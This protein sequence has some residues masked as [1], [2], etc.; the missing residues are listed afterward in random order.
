M[1][2][3][4]PDFILD[5]RDSLQAIERRLPGFLQNPKDTELLNEVFRGV[6]TIKGGSAFIPHHELEQ[7]ADKAEEILMGFR[8]GKT[9]ANSDNLSQLEN[10]IQNIK[11]LIQD[12]E[13]Q[14]EESA[15]TSW[16][17]QSTQSLSNTAQTQGKKVDI[18]IEG[19]EQNEQILALLRPSL[20]QILQ[21]SIDHGIE[22][23]DERAAAGKNENASILIKVIKD[24]ENLSITISDDGRGIDS[25]ALRAKAVAQGVISSE[26]ASSMEETDIHQLIF[27]PGLST[28]EHVTSTAG[29]G[30]GMDI[31]KS[32]IEK[33]GGRIAVESTPK[34]GCAFT[35]QVPDD[36]H[37]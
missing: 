26:Q 25:E 27:T 16:L 1:N 8:D 15:N 28:T 30:V 20:I 21:N 9:E 33:S 35:I 6:H 17:K 32:N 7:E 29:R 23:S 18:Q 34:Q 5:A 37:S 10:Q 24:G 4:I 3:L 22:P 2:D 12:L 19:V 13:K 11:N 14:S 36:N 31:V